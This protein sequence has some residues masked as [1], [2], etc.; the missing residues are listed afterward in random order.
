MNE[1]DRLYSPPRSDISPSVPEPSEFP[2]ASTNR[3]FANLILDFI[4]R[5]A[6]AFLVGAVLGTLHVPLGKGIPRLL[7]G[8]ATMLFYYVFLEGLFGFTFGKLVTG[9]RV[10][11]VDGRRPSFGAVLVRT[12]VR[13]VPFEPFS[14]LT[15][16]RGWHDRWSGTR[17]VRTRR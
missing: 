8:F 12:L 5:A 7:F 2:D 17:V 14:F 16:T 10:L 4:A 9:T 3:R 11:G 1:L 15:G 6:F 13:F